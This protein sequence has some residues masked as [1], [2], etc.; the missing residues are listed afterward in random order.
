MRGKAGTGRSQSVVDW[1]GLA[2]VEAPPAFVSAI[3]AEALYDRQNRTTRPTK[4]PPPNLE[5]A[6]RT[7]RYQGFCTSW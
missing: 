2:A 3:R 7:G 6:H 4:A 1:R 5:P